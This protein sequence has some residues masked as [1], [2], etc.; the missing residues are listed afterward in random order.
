MEGFI[1]T[2][3]EITVVV[4]NAS[5]VRY[6]FFFVCVLCELFPL[7][8]SKYLDYHQTGPK[9]YCVHCRIVY[10]KHVFFLRRNCPYF[11]RKKEKKKRSTEIEV[12]VGMYAMFCAYVC[13][14]QFSTSN[15]LFWVQSMPTLFFYL[16]VTTSYDIPI[17]I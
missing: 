12:S 8:D 13:R 10:R 5:V 17:H 3:C 2:K 11:C 16:G 15:C 1:L 4:E 7:K 9:I 6:T 14:L